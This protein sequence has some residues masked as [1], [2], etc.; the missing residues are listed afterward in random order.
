MFYAPIISE[1]AF[2]KAQFGLPAEQVNLT[3]QFVAECPEGNG[4]Q[5][6]Y[7]GIYA[8][9]FQSLLDVNSLEAEM[10]RLQ[11]KIGETC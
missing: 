4:I 5:K 8:D 1:L 10:R 6:R 11:G 2:I 7:L 9:I 3:G